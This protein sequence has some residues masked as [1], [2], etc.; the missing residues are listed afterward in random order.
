M[1]KKVSFGV[2]AGMLEGQP[3]DKQA[4]GEAD[5]AER[6]DTEQMLAG[7]PLGHFCQ[8]HLDGTYGKAVYADQFADHQAEHD[9]QRYGVEQ[10]AERHACEGDPGI[11]KS[12]DR[13]D[14]ETDPGVQFVFEILEGRLVRILGILQRNGKSQG[15]AG[16]RGMDSRLQHKDPEQCSDPHVR[17][18]LHDL[19]PVQDHQSHKADRCQHQHAVGE[20]TGIEEGD[21]DDGTEVIHDRQGEQEDFQRGWDPVAGQRQDSQCEGDIRCRRN[22]PAVESGAVAGVDHDIDDRRSQHAAERRDSGQGDLRSAGK[23]PGQNFTFDFEADHQEEDG[24]QAIVDPQQHRLGD[25]DLTSK[26]DFDR[27]VQKIFVNN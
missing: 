26:A 23:L 8:P 11:G 19:Q 15:N 1:G 24:H 6:G 16:Q 7:R 10:V 2:T 27:G 25:M 12:K 20:V 14:Q 22:R 5:P 13:Q 4:H 9:P 17:G 21:D 18:D 3:A